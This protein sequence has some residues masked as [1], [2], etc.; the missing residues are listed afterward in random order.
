MVDTATKEALHSLDA[1]FFNVRYDRLTP[2][3]QDYVL[4][5]ARLG[6]GA[7]AAGDIAKHL[8]IAVQQAGSIKNSLI[9]KGNG[10]FS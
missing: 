1:G 5:M 10:L 7:Q 4:A 8:G 6:P 3:E 9:K 2:R